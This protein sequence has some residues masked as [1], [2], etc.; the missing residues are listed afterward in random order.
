MILQEIAA[1]TRL[2]VEKC[3]MQKPL[4]EIKTAALSKKNARPFLFEQVLSSDDLSFICEVKKASPSKGI[5]ARDFPYL[6]IAVDYE[7]A[8]AAAVSVL[9][10]PEFFMGSDSYLQEIAAAV[11]IPVLRKDFTIDEYQIYEAALLGAGAVLLICALLSLEQLQH[12]RKIADILGL[13]CLIEAHD[14]A[15]VDKA[16]AA[17]ARVIGV[18]N[19][20]LR[21][22]SVDINNSIKLRHKVPDDI[23]FISESGI[24]T[25]EDIEH[26]RKNNVQAALIGEAL[27]RSQDKVKELTRLYGSVKMPRVK[28]CGI[29]RMEDADILN[30]VQPDYAGFIFAPS[31]RRITLPL[32][33]S[34][35]KV[36]ASSI[37][38]VGVF[39]NEVPK[40]IVDI[41][42]A[43][44]LDVIQLHGDETEEDINQIKQAS[45][46]DVWKVV[47][48]KNSGDIE[49]WRNSSADMLLFDTF[50]DKLA[51][52]TGRSFDWSVLKGLNRPFVLSGGLKS[53]NIVRAIRGVDPWGV[54]INS[55]VEIDGIKD[56]AK[57]KEIMAIIRRLK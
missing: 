12:F 43:L 20:D 57:I 10:E 2:R 45:G 23:I 28:F 55:G 51:G 53:I 42:H 44:A 15:E 17:G 52:G 50:C 30:M 56:T 38:T 14:A 48:V 47:R 37:D 29:T 21:D 33:Q 54:D 3:K 1:K 22:F 25:A 41:A 5:I 46:C 16:L 18:N 19:R 32:A 6:Q 36:L 27:M 8:G 11:D 40:T 24:K 7:K 49:K 13:S 35:K 4:E 9:T 34:I 26:L 31:K 39:V